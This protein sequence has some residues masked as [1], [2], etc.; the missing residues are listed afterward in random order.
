MINKQVFA[1]DNPQ[2]TTIEIIP[3]S[4]RYF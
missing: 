3:R 1:C 2:F 4:K